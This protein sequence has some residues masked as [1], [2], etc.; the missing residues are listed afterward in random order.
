MIGIRVDGNEKIAMGHVVRCLAIAEGLAESGQTCFFITSDES[1]GEII[2]SGGFEFYSLNSEWNKK[3]DELPALLNL[4]DKL[5][6]QVLIVDSYEVTYRYLHEL[7]NRTQVVYLDDLLMFDYPV[8]VIINYTRNISPQAYSD[9]KECRNFLL[10]P[11]Y[12]PLR[13]GFTSSAPASKNVRNMM[14]TSGG[15]DP[16]AVL[17]CIVTKL[18]ILEEWK[19]VQLHVVVGPFFDESEVIAF[20]GLEAA[21]NQVHIYEKQRNLSGIMKRCDMALSAGGTTLA[22]LCACGVP[23]VNYAVAENQLPGIW[24]YETDGLM[25]SAGDVRNQVEEGIERI[26]RLLQRMKENNTERM[27]FSIKMRKAVDGKGAERIAR[28]ISELKR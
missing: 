9:N 1:S 13:S 14:L 7:R 26:V 18:V 20:R 15:T 19:G 2:R 5:K 23:T 28:C 4:M 11:Q 24:A 10:G 6:L 25:L 8:D 22:E 17:Q 12:L 27:A 3:E 21:Y 16:Y